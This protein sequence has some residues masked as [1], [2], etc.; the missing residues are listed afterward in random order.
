MIS[1]DTLRDSYLGIDIQCVFSTFNNRQIR[2]RRKGKILKSKLQLNLLCV[3]PR[4]Y[5]CCN[6][7]IA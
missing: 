4:P 2:L 6:L 7:E 5:F 3:W 1:N